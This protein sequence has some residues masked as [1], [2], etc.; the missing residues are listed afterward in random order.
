MLFK[1]ILKFLQKINNNDIDIKNYKLQKLNFILAIINSIIIFITL[2]FLWISTFDNNAIKDFQTKKSI[3]PIV[4]LDTYNIW[5]GT[6]I[7]KNINENPAFNIKPYYKRVY[8]DNK[9]WMKEE[10]W[11][12]LDF[13]NS[14]HLFWKNDKIT[15]PVF[16]I[17][18][19]QISFVCIEYDDYL[20]H[21]YSIVFNT[22]KS[23]INGAWN[24]VFMDWVKE[25]KCLDYF[26][27]GKSKDTISSI[28]QINN[29]LNDTFKAS[30]E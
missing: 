25:S 26:F 5:S 17:W 21:T 14:Y 18:W 24:N 12:S 11:S 16:S 22:A 27:Y 1:N 3:M 10:I 23:K 9:E 20:W 30:L 13:L 8:N 28:N 29:L 4:V 15:L 6:I 2:L 19:K 7:L